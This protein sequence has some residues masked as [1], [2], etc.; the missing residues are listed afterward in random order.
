M[1]TSRFPR[2]TVL[3][4]YFPYDNCPHQPGPEPH[5]CLLVDAYEHEGKQ[6]VAVCY[7]T[8]AFDSPL[9]ARHDGLVLT[10]GKEYIKGIDLPKDRGNFIADHV[11][12]LPLDDEWVKPGV[13]GRLDFIRPESRE[14]DMHRA[15]LYA[16]YQ[17][18]ERAMVRATFDVV[19]SFFRTGN[20]GLPSGKRLR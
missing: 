11:A 14:R 2:G 5:Y 1:E 12:L 4:C 19:D 6:F 13:L 16:Q 3:L 15:R 18:L 20:F 7:G 9:F 8:S 17:S 10:V